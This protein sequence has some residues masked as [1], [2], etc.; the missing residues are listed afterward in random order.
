MARDSR[1]PLLGSLRQLLETGADND[2]TDGHLL[3]RFVV[4]QEEAA[5]TLLVRRH[6][7]LVQG[8]C[9]R[10][11]GNA[12][13]AE[14]AFQATFLVLVR[15]AA[16]LDRR[17]SLAGWLYGVAYRVA[18]RARARAA[19]R[20][21]CER[22][23]CHVRASS[24][25]EEPSDSDLGPILTEEVSRL[26][27]KYRSPIVLCY[28]EGK[29][30]AEAAQ[31]LRW[32]LGTVRG[33]VARAR[34]LLRRRLTRRGLTLSSA[35]LI[36]ALSSSE[37]GAVVPAA[38]L[39]VTVRAALLEAA[40]LGAAAGAFSAPATQLGEAVLREMTRG[41][42]KQVVAVLLI[43]ALAGGAGALVF[44]VGGWADPRV[45]PPLPDAPE[46]PEI[47]AVADRPL[48][49]FRHD[50]PVQA[51][52]LAPDGNTLASAGA[53][54]IRVWD[55]TPRQ[56]H[57]RLDRPNVRAV[58]F[59]PQRGYFASGGDE[60]VVHLWRDGIGRDPVRL[61]TSGDPAMAVKFSRGVVALA[62]SP[63]AATLATAGPGDLLRVWRVAAPRPNVIPLA[64]SPGGVT[65]L[66]FSADGRH[67]ASAGEE[68]KVRLWDRG[69][70][71]PVQDFLG[72]EGRVSS[73]VFLP[74]GRL[75]SGG[76]DG[77]IR[78]WQASTAEQADL[79][80]GHPQGVTALVVTPDGRI[81]VSAGAEG[82]IAV[83]QLSTGKEVRRFE[84]HPGGVTALS[85]SSNGKSLASGGLDSRVYLWE[86]AAER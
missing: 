84:A 45:P 35:T 70:N 41:R 21:E 38:T 23:A 51:V 75:A 32:P 22:E 7:P 46:L 12:A 33:R 15:K 25:P 19:R 13:D 42:L 39:N 18:V 8:L 1:D 79:W 9:R 55:L 83:W 14:D 30:H 57:H 73:V 65:A 86:L 36:A 80:R 68:G 29:S 85:L 10:L 72:H 24:T 6:G 69:T 71:R 31:Q 48:R 11:L 64:I 78:L 40:G 47:A 82:T 17:G 52:S 74:E 62:F 77:T 63:D 5:F 58:A 61:D 50:G 3:E 76:A 59:A 43:L 26:P 54:V 2:Q 16:G 53:D 44:R 56:Q 27:E 60:E 81:L 66:A 37:A 34:D 28:L 67:L 20:R 49:E 4:Q